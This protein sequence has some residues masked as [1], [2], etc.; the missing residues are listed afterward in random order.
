MVPE[1]KCPYPDPTALLEDYNDFDDDYD[2]KDIGQ[3]DL[4]RKIVVDL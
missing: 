2:D 3:Q 4:L 1:S